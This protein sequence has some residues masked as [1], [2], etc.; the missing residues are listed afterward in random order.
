MSFNLTWI[1]KIRFFERKLNLNKNGNAGLYSGAYGKYSIH[2][3]G[4]F[5][6]Y[7]NYAQKSAEQLQ[8]YRTHAERQRLSGHFREQ[9]WIYAD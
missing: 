7:L 8:W 4:E 5:P 2:L 3:I 1:I 6:K 9:V